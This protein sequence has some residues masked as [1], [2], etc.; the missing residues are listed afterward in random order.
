MPDGSRL[1]IPNYA[2]GI[3]QLEN[4]QKLKNYFKIKSLIIFNASPG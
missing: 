2:A 3:E 1:Q 4:G